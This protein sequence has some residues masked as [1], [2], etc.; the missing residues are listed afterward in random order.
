MTI[1]VT[2]PA[3]LLAKLIWAMACVPTLGNIVSWIPLCGAR[4]EARSYSR[5]NVLSGHVQ[6]ISMLQALGATAGLGSQESLLVFSVTS[7]LSTALMERSAVRNHSAVSPLTNNQQSLSSSDEIDDATRTREHDDMEQADMEMASMERRLH[8]VLMR[9][10][11]RFRF[12]TAI[13]GIQSC[14][15][16]LIRRSST[17]ETL[18]QEQTS[19]NLSM[20]EGGSDMHTPQPDQ[21]EQELHGGFH[22]PLAH[23]DRDSRQTQLPAST[24]NTDDNVSDFSND[25]REDSGSDSET[26]GGFAVN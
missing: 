17:S 16:E 20:N 15:Q 8:T 4:D 26:E 24:T 3:I 9:E 7:T 2:S 6:N 5:A 22:Q 11:V 14:T 13:N 21:I 1:F 25:S 23:E 12:N 19:R 18:E 10:F